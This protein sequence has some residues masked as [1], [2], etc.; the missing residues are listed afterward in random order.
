MEVQLAL[1]PPKAS[2]PVP[3][4]AL[5]TTATDTLPRLSVYPV[6]VPTLE[7][8]ACQP[9]RDA[10]V[11][12]QSARHVLHDNELACEGARRV[13]TF[14]RNGQ[15]RVTDRGD[16]HEGPDTGEAIA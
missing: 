12:V 6:S 15:G 13:T 8:P 11:I 4:G 3:H 1:R 10:P 2:D 7:Q 14:G 16:T 9:V 5:P